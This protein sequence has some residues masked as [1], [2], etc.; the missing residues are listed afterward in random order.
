MLALF[1]ETRVSPRNGVENNQAIFFQVT[2][3]NVKFAMN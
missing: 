3:V 1:A 2:A